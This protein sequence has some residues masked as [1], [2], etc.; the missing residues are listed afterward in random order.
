MQ[1][2][3]YIEHVELVFAG[4]VPIEQAVLFAS[5]Q[6]PDRRRLS[7]GIGTVHG[8]VGVKIE[9]IINKAVGL[10]LCDRIGTGC[11]CEGFNHNLRQLVRN[12]LCIVRANAVDRLRYLVNPERLPVPGF[13]VCSIDI[14]ASCQ[15]T[16][17]LAVCR[18]LHFQFVNAVSFFGNCT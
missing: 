3:L 14:L 16:K 8:L 4:T 2:Q 6:C 18:I 9:V 15:L 17:P 11:R 12:M 5:K 1:P 10:Q 7:D 13:I